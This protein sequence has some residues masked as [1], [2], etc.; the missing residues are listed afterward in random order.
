MTKLCNE[1]K[2]RWPK[3]QFWD[4]FDLT[5]STTLQ[6][7]ASEMGL[8]AA[9]IQQGRPVAYASRALT[10]TETQIE[11]ELLAI[12]FVA[13]KFHHYIYGRPICV[14]SDHKPLETIFKKPIQSSPK[15]LQR[16]ML[17]LQG[18]DITTTYKRGKEMFLAEPLS[19]AYLQ[20]TTDK[21]TTWEQLKVISVVW[22]GLLNK[23]WSMSMSYNTYQRK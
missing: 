8:G 7:D 11:K 23:S 17:R 21:K 2:S 5:V 19:R 3:P 14:E 20:G 22:C 15:R 1:S 10:V 18:Y 12:V 9:L 6:C 4:F 13:A 16:M